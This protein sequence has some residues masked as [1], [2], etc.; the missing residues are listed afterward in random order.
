MLLF[1][2]IQFINLCYTSDSLKS[3]AS[4]GYVIAVCFMSNIKSFYI[5]RNRLHFEEI[6]TALKDD[7]FQP[8]N[9]VQLQLIEKALN[10]YSRVKK[11]LLITSSIS[12]FSALTTPLFYKKNSQD[13]PM[14]A[15]YP[16]D[17][18]TT[19]IHTI[20]YIHQCLSVFYVSYT[21][22]Y[23]DIIFAGLATFITV[24]CDLLCDN[25]KNIPK[26]NTLF[27]CI[28]HHWKILE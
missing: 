2:V 17:I 25:L 13:L 14:S 11:F 7:G 9:S 12:V 3:V 23:V 18:S 10:S 24:Q 4:S 16:F 5:F 8:K 1:N 15:W 6:I 22:I 20:V 27:Q 28:L 19:F 21:N 26:E